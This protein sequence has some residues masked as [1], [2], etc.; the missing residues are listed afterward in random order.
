MPLTQPTSHPF[1]LLAKS[2]TSFALAI[3]NASPPHKALTL[4][5]K[6]HRKSAPFDSFSILFALKS[7]TKLQN[8]VINKHLHAHI[9][10]LGFSSHVYVATSLLYAYVVSSFDDA[11]KLFDK[12]PVGNTITWNTMI[13]GYSRL[14]DVEKARYLFEEMPERDLA[15][16]SAVISA[17]INSGYDEQSLSLFRDM[18]MNEGLKPDQVT[19]GS[20]LS[21]CAHMNSVGSLLGKSVHGFIAKNG[22]D[23]NVELGTDLVDMYAK[24]WAHELRCP[25]V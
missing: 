16:W 23:L 13:T 4:Y 12:M 10:K 11:C 14:G 25:G 20:V 1:F 17:H 21:G 2:F 18:V 9:I 15:S 8:L 22:W 5:S 24:V 3:R 7:C 19:V 6:M